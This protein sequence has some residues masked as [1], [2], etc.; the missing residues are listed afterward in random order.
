MIARK[1]NPIPASKTL[2][3]LP[4]EESGTI[5][6]YPKV[7]KVV[8]LKYKQVAR[9]CLVAPDEMSVVPSD[10]C[11]SPKP[12][13]NPTAHSISRPNSEQGPN[14]LSQPFCH[15]ATGNRRETR[16]QTVQV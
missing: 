6:P 7:T 5:S 12:A 9:L 1:P 11:S 10:Q 2:S 4:N 3:I 16:F 14:M 13:I 15:L 8:P